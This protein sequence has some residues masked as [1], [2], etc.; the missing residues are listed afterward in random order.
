MRDL[1]RFARRLGPDERTQVIADSALA[2]PL[3]EVVIGRRGA[4]VPIDRFDELFAEVDARAAA[5]TWSDRA[6]SDRWLAPLLHASLRLS[7]SQAADRATWEWLAVSVPDY[8]TWRWKGKDGVVAEDRWRGPVHKQSL[9][10]LWWGAEIF[11]DGSDYE[12]VRQAFANQDL[13]NSLLHRPMVRCRPLALGLVAA[14]ASNRRPPTSTEINNVARAVNLVT[15]G[16]PPEAETGFH[17]DDLG[18]YRQWLEEPPSPVEDWNGRVTGPAV[19]GL[20]EQTR[21]AGLAI[22]TRSQEYSRRT[23]EDGRS[24]AGGSRDAATAREV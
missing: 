15:A 21:A 1:Q 6:S 10:R 24:P 20:P 7:R 12:P 18:A 5:G 23:G 2:E 4:R 13:P 19:P 14:L 11:R 17:R 16:C 8:V 3:S 22:A 9:A